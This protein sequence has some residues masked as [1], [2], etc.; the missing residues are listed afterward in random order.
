MFYCL[1]TQLNTQPLILHQD[2]F[3]CVSADMSVEFI[4]QVNTPGSEICYTQLGQLSHRLYLT[5]LHVYEWPRST[6][7]NLPH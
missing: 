3:L 6:V 5:I 4:L 1:V 2:I 7:C